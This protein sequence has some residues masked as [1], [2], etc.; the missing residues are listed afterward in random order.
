MLALFRRT[1]TVRTATLNLNYSTTQFA[2]IPTAPPTACA[3]VAL[4]ATIAVP[5]IPTLG[6]TRLDTD[7]QTVALDRSG[8]VELDFAPTSAG[9]ADDW[10][11]VLEEV[12][13]NGTVATPAQLRTY[14]TLQPS[15]QIDPTLLVAGHMYL[16][17]TTARVGY[18]N[19]AMRDYR[20]ISYPFGTGV[21][22]SSVF[23][24]SP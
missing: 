18:P 4:N 12:T 11:I 9:S 20:M 14:S 16:F 8:L 6:G 24:V 3:S 17:Q 21:A 15:V 19:A 22:F 5:D 7:G 2:Q 13:V 1:A 23:T 10:S